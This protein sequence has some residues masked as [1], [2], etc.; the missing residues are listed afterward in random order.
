[1]ARLGFCDHVYVD[2]WLEHSLSLVNGQQN[3]YI[4]YNTNTG[5][6]HISTEDGLRPVFEDG[7]PAAVYTCEGY[8]YMLHTA[9]KTKLLV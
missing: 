5:E 9:C 1:M 6:M 2:G 3:A 4:A 8:N 7:S